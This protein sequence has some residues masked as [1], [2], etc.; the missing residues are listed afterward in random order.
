MVTLFLD[1]LVPQIPFPPR[2]PAIWFPPLLI[3]VRIHV[4][5]R[6]EA[7]WTE[8][9]RKNECVP[10]Q[11]SRTV[12]L[13]LAFLRGIPVLVRSDIKQGFP[14]PLMIS[15]SDYCMADRDL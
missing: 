4:G 11:T 3:H 15:R 2:K 9:H 5:T 7:A 10:P 14:K 6:Y 12:R 1:T 13:D 8:K